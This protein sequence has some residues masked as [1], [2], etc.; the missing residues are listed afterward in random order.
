M[1]RGMHSTRDIY[2]YIDGCIL[3]NKTGFLRL[4]H[5]LM[6]HRSGLFGMGTG[7]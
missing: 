6:P 1:R 3:H 5:M 7:K 2:R 4:G